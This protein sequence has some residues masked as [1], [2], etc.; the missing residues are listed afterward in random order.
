MVKKEIISNCMMGKDKALEHL[1]VE[2]K[3][4]AQF[5]K[6]HALRDYDFKCV[7]HGKCYNKKEYGN[8]TVCAYYG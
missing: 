5:S 8:N 4:N 7:Y 1:V 6:K 2:P 3:V